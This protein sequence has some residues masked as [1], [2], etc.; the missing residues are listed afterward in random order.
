[1]TAPTATLIS[2]LP[3]LIIGLEST[4]LHVDAADLGDI[5][6]VAPLK[7]NALQR[8]ISTCSRKEAKR[9]IIVAFQTAAKAVGRFHMLNETP[10]GSY[11]CP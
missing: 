8:S 7:K 2:S 9:Q 1:M 5:N 10:V 3:Y 6:R 4:S 11:I